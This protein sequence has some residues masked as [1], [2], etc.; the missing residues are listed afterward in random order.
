MVPTSARDPDQPRA[1]R[2][3]VGER[4]RWGESVFRGDSLCLEGWKVLE[5][6]VVVVHLVNIINANELYA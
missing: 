6:V 2:Q 5:I 1:P 4:L 3:E